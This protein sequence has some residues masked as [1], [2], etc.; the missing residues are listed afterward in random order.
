MPGM[1]AV[2]SEPTNLKGRGWRP[3]A[4]EVS[5]DTPWRPAMWLWPT[6]HC[7]PVTLELPVRGE[8]GQGWDQAPAHH[9]SWRSSW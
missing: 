9:G 4:V 1:G 8:G 2:V 3:G 7:G 5:V 6:R